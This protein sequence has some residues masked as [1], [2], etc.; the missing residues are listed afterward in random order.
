[1]VRAIDLTGSVERFFVKSEPG[2]VDRTVTFEEPGPIIVLEDVFQVH[3]G[4]Y[5]ELVGFAVLLH[6]DDEDSEGVTRV[7]GFK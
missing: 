7:F 4:L 1:M 2:W 3:S 6:G 5:F